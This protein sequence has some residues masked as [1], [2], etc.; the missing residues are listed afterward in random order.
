MTEEELKARLRSNLRKYRSEQGLTQEELAEKAGVSLSG[1]KNIESTERGASLEMLVKLGNAL[2]VDPASLLLLDDVDQSMSNIYRL[3]QNKPK[4]FIMAV[5]EI[6]NVVVKAT[7]DA[8][9]T[10]SGKS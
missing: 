7:E 9:A 8:D 1:Y 10:D 4:S 2:G 6:I 3:L 5:E